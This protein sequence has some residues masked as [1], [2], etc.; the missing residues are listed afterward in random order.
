MNVAPYTTVQWS[1]PP[2]N[3]VLHMFL[4]RRA[5]TH[6]GL[7]GTESKH[8]NLTSL[9]G[10][11]E[12]DCKEDTAVEEGRPCRAPGGA[13]R[14]VWQKTRERGNKSVLKMSKL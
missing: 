9:Q 1:N 14:A 5:V 7:P 10:S 6:T 11:G 3:G 13:G 12:L 4:P 8:I 2:F